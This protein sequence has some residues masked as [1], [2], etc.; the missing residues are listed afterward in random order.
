MSVQFCSRYIKEVATAGV[1]SL[2]YAELKS[3]QARVIEKFVSGHDVFGV[4]PTGYGRA[5]VG[6]VSP[7]L[8]SK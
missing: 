2:G 8:T 1:T 4:L 3:H 5:C 7:Q 6:L